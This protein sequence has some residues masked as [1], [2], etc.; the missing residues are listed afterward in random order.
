M[1]ILVT[2]GH[3]TPA[4]AFMEYVQQSHAEDSLVLVGRTYSQS[5]KQQKAVEATA[6]EELNIPFKNLNVPKVTSYL[7]WHVLLFGLSYLSILLKSFIIVFNQKPSV[8]LSF[9]GYFAVP[10]C[11]AAWVQGVPIVTHEQTTTAGRANRF[12]ASLATKVA[13]S[14]PSSAEHFAKRKTVLTGNPIRA[15]L[16]SQQV[17]Q[18]SWYETPSTKPI[19]YITGGNQGSHIINTVVKQIL[20]QLTKDFVVI[21]AC[22]RATA[23]TNYVE[24]LQQAAR[25]LP[26]THQNRYFVREWIQAP[27]L[28]WIL[29]HAQLS[30]SRAG[31]NTVQELMQSKVPAILVPLPFSYHNEQALNAKIMTDHGGA[32]TIPQKDLSPQK[33]LET[34]KEVASKHKAFRR[35]LDL[36][37][38]T[39]DASQ[40]VYKVA[41][42]AATSKKI[43]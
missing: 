41:K 23:T 12:I 20:R 21:H 13:I 24:E 42:Q 16:M 40:K 8:I 38:F 29:Q 18:P 36:I 7:P 11:I 32:I 37:E 14:F 22:G 3:I 17:S 9:G 26:S 15:Q 31:A 33:L 1:K 30:I 10:I 6:A 25:S 39:P 28:A 2:G 4:I 27:E 34:V 35:K 43:R 5:S 19:I